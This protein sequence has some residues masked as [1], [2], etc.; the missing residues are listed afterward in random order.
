MKSSSIED[1]DVETLPILLRELLQKDLK[2][3]TIEGGHFQEKSVPCRGFNRSI[4]VIV[5]KS[6]LYGADRFHSHH[7]DAAALD[8]MQSKS[9]F[10]LTKDADRLIGRFLGSKTF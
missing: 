9:A 6:K 2:A 8:G 4:K 7:G 10:I 1:D 3:W 5:G